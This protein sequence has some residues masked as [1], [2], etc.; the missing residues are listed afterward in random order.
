MRGLRLKIRGSVQGV[1]FRPWVWRVAHGLALQGVV[2]NA[3]DGVEIRVFGPKDALDSFRA[4]LDQPP[5]G[6][7]VD[8]IESEVLTTSA[9][10]EFEIV[11]S[12]ASVG[13]TSVDVPLAP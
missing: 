9:P 2:Y 12:R 6:S 13:A 5:G 1:G 4:Q 7:V 8:A 11:E 10:T 3:P